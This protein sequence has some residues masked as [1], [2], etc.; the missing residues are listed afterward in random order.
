MTIYYWAGIPH[1]HFHSTPYGDG[2]DV[3]GAQGLRREVYV[4]PTVQWRASAIPFT[5]VRALSS[6]MAVACWREPAVTSASPHRRFLRRKGPESRGPALSA[7]G[8]CA[9]LHVA[10]QA[11]AEM[12]TC[13][14]VRDSMRS[15]RSCRLCWVYHRLCQYPCAWRFLKMKA[16][17]GSDSGCFDMAPY[18]T[19][20]AFSP[21]KRVMADVAGPPT[22]LSISR[23]GCR[24]D[25]SECC[26]TITMRLGDVRSS[27]STA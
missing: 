8:I 6:Q 22:Q 25:R 27:T 18:D 19:R 5:V 20:C 23:I 12:L 7:A 9:M 26:C 3:H 15:S 16:E 11:A 13:S 10:S 24:N 4:E 2:Q 14:A 1:S 21:R 17:V